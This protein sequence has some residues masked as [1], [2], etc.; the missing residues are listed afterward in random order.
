MVVMISSVLLF[1]FYI[2]VLLISLHGSVKLANRFLGPEPDALPDTAPHFDAPTIEPSGP[3][4]PY[5]APGHMSVA[6]ERT[7]TAISELGFGRSLMTVFVQ[8]MAI[9]L[10]VFG[11]VSLVEATGANLLGFVA[12]PA[13]AALNTVVL[14]FLLPTTFPRALLV[15]VMQ[16]LLSVSIFAT[17]LLAIKFLLY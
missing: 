14:R 16:L 2:P 4:N 6:V 3:E 7:V 12:L 8:S 9:I 11:A 1:L 15:F 17:A 5:S 13:L 10:T